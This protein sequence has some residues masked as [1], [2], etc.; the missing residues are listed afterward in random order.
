MMQIVVFATQNKGY[1]LGG[2]GG[3]RINPFPTPTPETKKAKKAKI[4]KE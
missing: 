4:T 1:E 2:P 3:P